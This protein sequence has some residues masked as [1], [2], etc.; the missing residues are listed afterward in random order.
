[1]T[2]IGHPTFGKRLS[3]HRILSKKGIINII[4]TISSGCKLPIIGKG[5][6]EK[7]YLKQKMLN[8]EIYKAL[9]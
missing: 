4:K 1:M 5:Y 7:V 9:N 3:Q 8:R 6:R 2:N